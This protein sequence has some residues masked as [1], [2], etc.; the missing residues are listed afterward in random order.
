MAQHIFATS[1][2]R[3]FGSLGRIAF[4]RVIED[5]DPIVP[6]PPRR[7][8]ELAHSR[9]GLPTYNPASVDLAVTKRCSI[10][11]CDL[12]ATSAVTGSTRSKSCAISLDVP[13]VVRGASWS[14]TAPL[15]TL[16]P[17]SRLRL[18]MA[19]GAPNVRRDHRG[20]HVPMAES[21]LDSPNIGTDF[22]HRYSK[23]VA[24]GMTARSLGDRC[25]P[26]RCLH[27]VL[28]H[29]ST[30]M[31]PPMDNCARIVRTASIGKSVLPRPSPIGMRVLSRQGVRHLDSPQ[32]L[33]P[34]P[35][36]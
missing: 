31:M 10:P 1:A 16:E 7:G 3:S 26:Y 5:Q 22:G 4:L 20:V 8:R 27:G 23:R 34:P 30:H 6:I 9:V 29:Q 33:P 36:P 32:D 24:R 28:H 12:A 21:C 25:F 35:Q 13:R 2:R 11:L 19:G 18:L 17:G 15:S 14:R